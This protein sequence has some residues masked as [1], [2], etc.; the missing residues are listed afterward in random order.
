MLAT[1]GDFFKSKVNIE[2]TRISA[3]AV[4]LIEAQ[5][6]SVVTT[7]TDKQVIHAKLNPFK[8]FSIPEVFVPTSRNML[9]R[10]TS[11]DRRG[12][13]NHFKGIFPSLNWI[14]TV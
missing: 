8:Y 5:G 3:E 11:N 4:K 10:Y 14:L 1:G 2:V 7:Y 6:G 9:A 12:Y 13:L